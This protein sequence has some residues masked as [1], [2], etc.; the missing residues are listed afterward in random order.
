MA[1]SFWGVELAGA[2]GVTFGGV[3]ATSYTVKSSEHIVAVA[4]AGTGGTTVQVQVHAAGGDTADTEAD[5]FAYMLPPT[6]TGVSPSSGPSTGGMAVTITGTGLK[7]VECVTFGGVKA[8]EWWSE[9]PGMLKVV[10]P[11]HAA[12]TVKVNVTTGGGTNV[13]DSY[14]VFTY[15]A[16]STVQQSDPRI[17][18][19]GEWGTV[20]S[21]Y[22]SGGSLIYGATAGCQFTVTFEGNYLALVARMGP[23]LGKAWV[24]VDGREDGYVDFYSETSRYQQVVYTTGMIDSGAHTVTFKW[25]DIHND[26]S[27]GYAINA[28]VIQVLGK[29]TQAP[30]PTQ[31]QQSDGNL[32]YTGEW[33]GVWSRWA[34]GGSFRWVNSPGAS[35]N[36]EFTGTY[37]AWIAKKGPGYGKAWVSLDGSD[38]VLVDLYSS[39]DKFAQRVYST[40]LLEDGEHNLSVYWIGQKNWRATA[41]RISIDAFE[42]LG[43]VSDAGDADPIDWQYEQSDGRITYLGP[44]TASC[45]GLCFRR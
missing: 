35:V 28:D 10:A 33:S 37:C 9:S 30:V 1:A 20:A 5:D 17:A 4:P 29:V 18:F 8:K 45:D 44:W 14:N 6:V 21:S 2:G 31:Y 3:N 15:V 34:S 26:R 24:T 25:A 40:G 13:D 16:T 32:G 12:G 27:T 42:V 22:A 7:E 38:P 41:C 23:D 43:E 39:Y 19:L 36:L 11:A